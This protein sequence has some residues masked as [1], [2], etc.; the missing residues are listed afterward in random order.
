[1]RQNIRTAYNYLEKNGI[2]YSFEIVRGRDLSKA[3]ENAV[4]DIYL[5]RRGDHNK[6]DSAVHKFY[7]K[8]L[9]YYTVAHRKLES[10]YFGILRFEGEIAAFWSG[11]ANPNQDYISCPRLALNGKFIRLSPGII[12]LCETAKMLE[13]ETG[14]CQL[15]LSRGNHDYK[16]RMGGENYF[17]HDYILE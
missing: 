6:T 10:S 16:M 12:L 8:H 11:F 13:Q 9:H 14:I 7:L 5:G 4:M 3:D 1:M 17:S 2:D 15:D